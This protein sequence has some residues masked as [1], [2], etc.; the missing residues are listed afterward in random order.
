MKKLIDV[1]A[2]NPATSDKELHDM[3]LASEVLSSAEKWQL[4]EMIRTRLADGSLSES[5]GVITFNQ[6]PD[7]PGL[8]ALLDELDDG[9]EDS[10]AS[11]D[12]GDAENSVLFKDCMTQSVHWIVQE[13]AREIGQIPQTYYE[14]LN[15]LI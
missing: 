8:S 9:G 13:F 5:S 15:R 2:D 3:V 14:A 7:R 10:T 6:N 1:I 11:S 12:P 4:Q